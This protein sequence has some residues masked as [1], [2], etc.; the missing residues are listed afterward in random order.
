MQRYNSLKFQEAAMRVFK[1]L[2]AL[3]ITLG[4]TVPALAAGTVITL[5]APDK[6]GGKPLMQALAERQSN[7]SF[8]DT[9][10]DDQTLGNLLWATWG[11]NRADGKRTAP[12]ARNTQ[13]ITVYVSRADGVWIYQ[14]KEHALEQVLSAPLGKPFADAP[15]VLLFAVPAADPA[16][17]MHAGSLYQNAGLY[18]ASAGLANVVKTSSVSNPD[19][20]ADLKL[21][22]GQ[23]LI[24]SHHIG[25]PK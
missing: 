17:G 7:R 12:T 6:T 2:P 24:A 21:P 13:D 1:L 4:L 20:Y 14:P 25:W 9:A 22:A 18:C 8:S 10:L 16:A 15:L 11:I 5:P 3:L 23:V 19:A